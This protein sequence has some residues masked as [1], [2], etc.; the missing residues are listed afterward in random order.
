MMWC[1]TGVGISESQ[2]VA[3]PTNLWMNFRTAPKSFS[4]S[5]VTVQL[6]GGVVGDKWTVQ[7]HLA[8]GVALC[9]WQCS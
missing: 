1:L 8:G 7:H 9:L 2:L 3:G 4:R 5:L 6:D